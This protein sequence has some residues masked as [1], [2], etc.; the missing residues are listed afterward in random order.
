MAY[1]EQQQL[2]LQKSQR[3]RLLDIF[4]V[5]PIL[6]GAAIYKGPMPP[7][8]RIGV[9]AIAIGTFTYNLKNFAANIDLEQDIEDAVRRVRERAA[10]LNAWAARE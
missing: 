7:W 2:G 3:V 1:L 10:E 9:G 8:L 6:L 5:A 4:V